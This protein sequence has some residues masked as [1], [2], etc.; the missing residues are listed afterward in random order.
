MSLT[1]ILSILALHWFAD[2]VLQTD[3]QAKN[4]SKSMEALTLHVGTYTAV[5]GAYAYF[6]LPPEAGMIWVAFNCVMHFVTDFVTS[7][8]NT[9]LWNRGQVHYFF[10]SV[11][12]DQLI[13][14]ACLF[15]SLFYL[16]LQ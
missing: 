11:G 4:K 10:V 13:H 3:W 2:F 6:F 5:I 16:G 8:V 1:A 14:Y 9:A 15:G 7:R 12:F